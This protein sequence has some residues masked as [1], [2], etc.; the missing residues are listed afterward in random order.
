MNMADM[1]IKVTHIPD[2]NLQTTEETVILESTD[3]S[4]QDFNEE[5]EELQKNLVFTPSNGVLWFPCDICNRKSA[6]AERLRQHIEKKHPNGQIVESPSKIQK[7]VNWCQVNE[8]PGQ[9]KYKC[10]VCSFSCNT[11]ADLMRHYKKHKG[12]KPYECHICGKKFAQRGNLRPHILTHSGVKP[13]KCS[14]CNKSF[15]NRNS[16]NK[17]VSE[18]ADVFPCR[19]CPHY[20]FNNSA[21][22]NEHE[23]KLHSGDYVDCLICGLIMSSSTGLRR[24]MAQ[25]HPEFFKTTLPIFQKR[26][27]CTYC[28]KLF[29][30][31]AYLAVHHKIHTGEKPFK[32]PEKDCLYSAVSKDSLKKHSER[33]HGK[34]K[35]LTCSLCDQT[36]TYYSHKRAHMLKHYNLKPFQCTECNRSFYSR[37]HLQDH[38]RKHTGDAK[39][40]CDKCDI[41]YILPDSLRKHYEQHLSSP[42]ECHICGKKFWI[43]GRYNKHMLMH[44]REY[45][46]KVNPRPY[47]CVKCNKRFKL[48]RFLERHK[49]QSCLGDQTVQCSECGIAVS[50]NSYKK[51]L[52]LNHNINEH[53]CHICTES[54]NRIHLYQH[55]METAH[56]GYEPSHVMLSNSQL[57]NITLEI[58]E[59]A[60]SESASLN[61]SSNVKCESVSVYPEITLET[62][63]DK[64]PL[65]TVHFID[66][67]ELISQANSRVDTSEC[68]VTYECSFCKETCYSFKDLLSH[69]EKLHLCEEMLFKQEI[70]EETNFVEFDDEYSVIET[71]LENL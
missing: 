26:F 67:E 1:M 34:M 68:E 51:H 8:T 60:E 47:K 69:R 21:E 7:G 71:E 14:I 37:R 3:P 48:R 25:S 9:D 42:I 53:C 58:S 44:R 59:I 27:E 16:Y 23:S 36:F 49:E 13:F 35:R 54:F 63:E 12:L 52:K 41:S 29:A 55:H 20:S 62:L 18:H 33:A 45:K 38:M 56:V 31:K 32:C 46:N 10:N 64:N 15:N 5:Y 66:M 24:H 28:H 43:T 61:H 19:Y 4:T 40:R 70:V 57:S 22:R 6:T 39:Y 65:E 30:S 17:H 50:A 2:E 11:N